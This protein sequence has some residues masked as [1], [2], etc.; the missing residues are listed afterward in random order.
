[1]VGESIYVT[2][3]YKPNTIDICSPPDTNNK[4]KDCNCQFVIFQLFFT[5]NLQ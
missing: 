5:D 3:D 2:T 4:T 1:M